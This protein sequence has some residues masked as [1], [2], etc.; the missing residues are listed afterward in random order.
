MSLTGID[1]IFVS[2]LF[3]LG[4][5]RLAAD[6]LALIVVLLRWFWVSLHVSA[7]EILIGLRAH[8][9][10]DVGDAQL[11]LVCDGSDPGIILCFEHLFR[12]G[13]IQITKLRGQDSQSVALDVEL[14]ELS[15]V[16]DLL[17]QR[18]QIIIPHTQYLQLA[19][20]PDVGG[21]GLEI[22]VTQIEG[23]ESSEVEEVSGQRALV[24]VVVGEVQHFQSWQ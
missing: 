24:Q 14:F 8:I 18:D 4:G 9:F 20:L 21:Q 7:V 3:V 23:T 2:S 22:V 16:P 6:L 15:Q 17:R 12:T 19:Q 13:Q 1:S 11:E 5:Q 10:K